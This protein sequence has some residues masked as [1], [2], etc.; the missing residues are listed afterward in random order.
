MI[1]I[2]DYGAGN[3]RSVSNALKRLGVEH[4]PICKPD[5]LSAVEKIILPGVGQFS[6]AAKSLQASGLAEGLQKTVA[7]GV[8]LLGICLGMQ[9]LFESSEESLGVCGLGFLQAQI[10]KLDCPRVPHMGWSKVGAVRPTPMLP[11]EQEEY[12]YF[13]HSFTAMDCDQPFVCGVTEVE[14]VRFVSAIQFGH[15]WGAQFH[16]EKSGEAG[17]EL[18][19]RFVEL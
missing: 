1:G 4:Q 11:E 16:P 18:I 7:D 19:R 8:P 6:S 12:F 9:L 2:V 13:A 10:K 5:E 14:G 17:A 15:V 3:L